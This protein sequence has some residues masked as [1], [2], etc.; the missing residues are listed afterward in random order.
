VKN[1]FNHTNLSEI[2]M[3]C[4][5]GQAIL[6]PP[7]I[8]AAPGTEG[9]I[10]VPARD[11]RDG[12]ILELLFYGAAKAPIDEFHIRIGKRVVT[13]P[14]C[15]GPAP[16][17]TETNQS[18][19]VQGSDFQVVFSKATGLVSGG[20]FRGKRIIEGGPFLNLGS[21]P[22]PPWWLI[23]M[24]HISTADEVVINLVGAHVARHGS[25]PGMS[26]EFEIR[27]DGQGLITTAYTLHDPVKA[28]NEVGISYVLSSSIDQ[29]WWDRKALWSAYPHD[30]IGRP[31]GTARRQSRFAAQTYRHPPA[32]PWCEDTKDF[33]LFG[34]DDPSDRGT[35]DFRSLKENIWYAS[36]GLAGAYYQVRAESDGTASARVE[37]RPDGKV[38]FNIDNLWAYTDLSYGVSMPPLTLERE[39]SNAV[40][41]RLMESKEEAKP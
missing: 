5:L 3:L 38:Q 40:R 33:F 16:E 7:T 24:R 39:Y 4:R 36:C 15:K 2:K 26:T 9:T 1:W 27:I 18:L 37:V 13:F 12:E 17:V 41:L 34:P 32:G 10:R 14:G 31:Q 20:V 35:N 23:N 21:T 8:N 28:A 6:F 19:S 30:H 29:L 22:L 11:W 25:G